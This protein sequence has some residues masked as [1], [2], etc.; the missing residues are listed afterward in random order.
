[1]DYACAVWSN[2]KKGN[3]YKLQRAQNYTAR[4]MSGSFY[5]IISYRIIDLLHTLRWTTVRERCDYFRA[6]LYLCT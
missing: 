2:T 6:V 4:I 1:M 5:H 3:I